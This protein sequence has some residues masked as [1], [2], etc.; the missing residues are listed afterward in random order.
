MVLKGKKVDFSKVVKMIDDMVAILKQ[1]QLD[2]D[3]K[4]EVCNMQLD[5]AEDKIKTL[6]VSIEDITTSLDQKTEAIATLADEI[7]TL[8]GEVADLDKSVMEATVQRK[9]ENAEYTELMS[10]DNAAKEVLL[11]AKNR[12]NQFYNPKLHK[13]PPKR[14][15]SEQE[16]IATAMGSPDEDEEATLFVQRAVHR[17]ADTPGPPPETWS[18][19]AK[20]SEESAGVIEMINLLIRDLEKEMTEAKTQELE[21][22]K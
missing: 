18:A 7:K 9:S 5:Q 13:A 14:E 21:D 15:M 4:R 1:E 17:V 8:Q 20:K 6:K 16:E 10:S 12:L 19:Y 2:D 22:Q 11:F 3:N